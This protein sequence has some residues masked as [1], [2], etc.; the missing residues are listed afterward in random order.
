V[1]RGSVLLAL[2]LMFSLQG[3]ANADVEGEL[4]ETSNGIVIS[5]EVYGA[6]G[7]GA[8]SGYEYSVTQLPCTFRSEDAEGDPRCQEAQCP[9]NPP[10]DAEN[11]W[12]YAQVERRLA[13]SDDP[14]RIV[15]TSCLNF[16]LIAPQVTPEMA[17]A[18]FLQLLPVLAFGVQPAAN[19]VVNLP[20]IV[21]TDATREFGFPP[22]DIVGQAVLIRTTATTYEW[23]FG[24]AHLTTDWP[25]RAF[26]ND[27]NRVPC[28]GYVS[29]PFP[30]PGVFDIGLT[31]T[32]VGEFSVSGGPWQEIPG[33]GT[34]NSP[35]QPVTVLEAN[36]VLTDPYD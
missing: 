13:G 36:A 3:H 22:V 21:Y 27:C 24:G 2:L 10:D 19:S 1:R 29:Y 5:S 17:R 7:G 35:A 31:V 8:S 33:V 20:V 14:W 16:A 11:Q 4:N 26:A 32:W 28:D 23:D 6:A 34:T 9:G 15:G 25:G 30:G 12:R 18:E